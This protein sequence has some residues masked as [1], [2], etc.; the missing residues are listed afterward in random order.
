MSDNTIELIRAVNPFPSPVAAPS[1]ELMVERLEGNQTAAPSAGGRGGSDR[2]SRLPPR[3]PV[4]RRM[5]GLWRGSGAVAAFIVSVAAVAVVVVVVA[6]AGR[7]SHE[8]GSITTPTKPQTWSQQLQASRR[9]LIDELAPLRRPQTATERAFAQTL[10]RH[11]VPFSYSDATIDRSL[12]RYAMTTPWGERLYL[13]PLSPSNPQ[14]VRA[15]DGAKARAPAPVEDVVVYSTGGRDWAPGN[16]ARVRSG[17]VGS[18]AWGPGGAASGVTQGFDLVPD[19]VANVTYVLPRQPDGAQYG[20]PTYAT[21]QRLSVRVQGNIAAYQTRRRLSDRQ[22]WIWYAADGR[23]VRRFGDP[24]AAA[25]VV[26]VKQPGPETARSRA[27]ERDPSTPNPVSVTPETVDHTTSF[28]LQFRA[29]LNGAVYGLNW[30]GPRCPG[31][32]FPAGISGRPGTILLRGSVVTTTLS[33]SCPGTYHVSVRVT[34]L[35]PI[36]SIRPAGRKI[37]AK[38]FGTATFALH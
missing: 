18:S 32:R 5:S 27:A 16:A 12:V 13:V 20:Y 25:K 15:R 30:T 38:P 17:T 35:E 34:G 11:Q 2:E 24:A 21:V 10:N 19:G 6:L 22:V 4:S 7:G 3:R 8:R 14:Q 36:G 31:L 33:P 1:F 29:L 23:V 26:P 28:K 37:N 9:A